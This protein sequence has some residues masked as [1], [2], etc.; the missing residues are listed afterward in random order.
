MKYILYAKRVVFI[1][2][3]MIFIS[4]CGYRPSSKYARN[5]TGE[6]I[7]TSVVISAEDP[8]NTVIIKDA[9]DRA[10]LEIFRA[11]LT[12]K[13]LA[14]THLKISIGSPSYAPIQYDSNGYVVGYRTT[15]LL[16]IQKERNGIFKNY[17]AKGTYDFSV[18]AN[19]IITDQQR[20]DAIK[21][22]AAKAIKSFIAQVSAEGSRRNILR[23]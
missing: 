19:A 6:K 23:K 15:I 4:A 1:V 10:I 22:S 16:T 11:R 5:V 3:I 20:F 2:T 9:V 14:D 13:E 12:S 21:L 8:E 17:H 18:V 7:S